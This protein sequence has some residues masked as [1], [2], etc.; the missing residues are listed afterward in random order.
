MMPDVRRLSLPVHTAVNLQPRQ[1]LGMADRRVKHAFVPRLPVD[2]DARYERS[3]PNN[4]SIETHYVGQ[5]LESLRRSLGDAQRESYRQSLSK[6]VDG[7]VTFFNRSLDVGD[8]AT[9]DWSFENLESYTPLWRLHLQ[10]FEP[11]R[12]LILAESANDCQADHLAAVRSFVHSWDEQ[13]G[14]GGKRYLRRAWVPHAVSLRVLVLCRLTAWLT[15]G[16]TPFAQ[17]VRQ[18]AFKNARFLENHVEH[19]VGGNHLV[20]NGIALLM[21]GT[22]FTDTERDW[23]DRGRSILERCARRQFLSDGGHFERSP[24]YHTLMLQRYL[25]AVELL[26]TADETS[27]VNIR[28]TARRAVEFLAS[29]APPDRRIPLLND[30]A[31]DEFLPLESCLRFA[32]TV[33]V[34]GTD[35]NE[36]SLEDT[37]YFWL[38]NEGSRLLIDCGPVG[39]SHL[40]GHS[41][42]DMLSVMLWVDGD[43][44]L[45][46]TGVYDYV[47]DETRQYVR[48]VRAHNTVQVGDY[49][50]IPIGGQFLMGR[51]CRPRASVDRGRK[52]DKFTGQYE[53]RRRLSL[54]YRHRRN[55]VAGEGW[56]II[57]DSVDGS[58]WANA[59]AR[60]HFHPDVEIDRRDERIHFERTDSDTGHGV[61][62]PFGTGGLEAACT[63]YF[64]RFGER[65]ERPS[66]RLR[67]N[68]DS[69]FN[70]VLIVVGDNREVNVT[71]EQTDE[72]SVIIDG[73]EHRFSQPL[74]PSE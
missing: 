31:F 56:W 67:Y 59:N 34:A 6:L 62:L 47:P 65:V 74:T 42:N 27:P 50:P 9:F 20:E 15:D 69:G 46:D 19:D 64:P 30:A 23:Q 43:R 35:A 68:R 3:I 71:G 1:I 60:F 72:L 73:C 32:E 40:P 55:V 18:L 70:G 10:A 26:S 44:I 51:R 41:H 48:S 53:R 54:L 37:G 13:V 38:G 61:I 21:A 36:S 45:T 22:L 2:F 25:T 52:Y 28:R 8:P 39:P 14:L 58:P 7:R 11:I 4:P 29:L 24:M 33:G 66:I 63:P 12:W 5:N 17:R 57:V 49:E 16:S